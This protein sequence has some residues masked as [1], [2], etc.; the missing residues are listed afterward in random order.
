MIT[1]QVLKA[2]IDN[3]SLSE[4]DG[5][6]FKDI[7]Q[8]LTE[9]ITVKLLQSMRADGLINNA[10]KKNLNVWWLTAKGADMALVNVETMQPIY[11]QESQCPASVGGNIDPDTGESTPNDV[12]LPEA[13]EDDPSVAAFSER[14]DVFIDDANGS[15]NKIGF[16]EFIVLDE[17]EHV[18][19]TGFE[20]IT[21]AI[22]KAHELAPFG[23]E[24]HV[25]CIARRRMGSVKQVTT[26][27]WVAV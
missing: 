14:T 24:Y 17:N 15:K 26:T 1:N 27:Q 20:T 4:N 11:E 16:V 19:A 2:L 5:L 7:Q 9:V 25:E 22:H 12:A 23:G 10:M 18:V 13:P 6:T 3:A 8:C 21:D